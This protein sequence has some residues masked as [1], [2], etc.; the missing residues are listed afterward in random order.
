VL[1]WTCSP[2]RTNW[3]PDCRCSI[4]KAEFSAKRWKIIHAS[5]TKKPAMNSSIPRTSPNKTYM[6]PRATSN[7]MP[8]ACSHRCTLTK[9]VTKKPVK[10][11]GPGQ[12]T[13]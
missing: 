12:I 2:S 1:K 7:G 5:V 3:V 8:K 13:I 4:L 6:R 9:S 11:L 10:S